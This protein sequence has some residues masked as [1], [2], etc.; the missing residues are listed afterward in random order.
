MVF[1][2]DVKY[3]V[4]LDLIDEYRVVSDS[5]N[6]SIREHSLTLSIDSHFID[7]LIAKQM[8]KQANS[9]NSYSKMH[10]K[11][12]QDAI[13]FQGEED[14]KEYIL[15]PMDSDVDSYLKY[16]KNLSLN[17]R[18]SELKNE[19]KQL[20]AKKESLVK[21]NSL[22][23]EKTHSIEKQ[24]DR[25]KGIYYTYVDNIIFLLVKLGYPK[26]EAKKMRSK[27]VSDLARTEE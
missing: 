3:D 27:L 4:L 23:E 12:I 11:G 14:I 16:E 10:G 5:Y 17:N 6:S 1:P 21:E 13:H 18:V 9:D 15:V 24:I 22:L 7:Y 25:L 8:E 19:L 20:E 26:N 2:F